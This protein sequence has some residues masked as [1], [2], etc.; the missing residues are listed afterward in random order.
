MKRL[1]IDCHCHLKPASPP[2][3]QPPAFLGR[4]GCLKDDSPKVL[5]PTGSAFLPQSF[6][7]NDGQGCC[8]DQVGDFLRQQGVPQGCTKAQKSPTKFLMY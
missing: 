1:K 8:K 4:C 3:S 2:T 7:A 5:L 6:Q